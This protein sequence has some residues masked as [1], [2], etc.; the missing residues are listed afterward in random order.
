MSFDLSSDAFL[1]FSIA[2][3]VMLALLGLEIVFLLIGKPLS[4]LLDH[5]TGHHGTDVVA[6][7]H[8]GADHGDHGSED[9]AHGKL[10]AALAWLNA[11]RVPGLILLILALAWF[12]A[13]GFVI[14]GVADSI[15][16]ALPAWIASLGAFAAMLPTVRLSSRAVARILPQ[17]ETY[18]ASHGD[19]VGMTGVVVLGPVQAGMVA[20]ARFRDLH[21]NV[22][23]PRIEPFN[24]TDVI[25]SGAAVLA[26]EARGATIAVT[27]ARPTLTGRIE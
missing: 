7:D 13:S 25:E 8:A 17:D 6:S 5:L 4:A 21:G 11:G 18:V 3:G 24:P 15:A 23:F 9:G 19:L 10:A 27:R 14:Q 2:G 22:H 16:N 20:K 26:V 1:P 12:S